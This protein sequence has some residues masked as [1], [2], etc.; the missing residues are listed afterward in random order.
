LQT[1]EKC[2][3]LPILLILGGGFRRP[4]PLIIQRFQEDP[5]GLSAE[6]R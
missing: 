2:Y 6:S 1:A 4:D 5:E 3:E